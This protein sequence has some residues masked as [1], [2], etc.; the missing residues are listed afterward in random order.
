MIVQ[1]IRRM[2][3][4]YPIIV[5]SVPR[6]TKALYSL[7]DPDEVMSFLRR[8]ARWKKASINSLD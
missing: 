6:E 8:L 2:G 1:V 3:R 5:S 7:H 4:G